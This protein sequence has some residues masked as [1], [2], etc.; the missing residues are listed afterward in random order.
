MIARV[1]LSG[2]ISS[3]PRGVERVD[4]CNGNI[5]TVN[6]QWWGSSEIRRG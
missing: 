4:E 6:L 1:V 5:T 3:G 2:N